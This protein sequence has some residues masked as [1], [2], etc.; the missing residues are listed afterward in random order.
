[1]TPPEPNVPGSGDAARA[2]HTRSKW[3]FEIG[4]DG[5]EQILMGIPPDLH[6]ALGAQDPANEPKLFKRYRDAPEVPTG[7]RPIEAVATAIAALVADGQNPGGDVTPDLPTLGRLLQ[8]SNGIL[9]TSTTP[10]GKEIA[11]RAAGQTGARFHLELYLVTGDLPGLPAGVYHYD[12]QT[13]ALRS[14][15]RGDYRRFVAQA[16]GEEPAIAAAPAILI[17]TSQIWRNAWRYL[18][19]SYRHVPWDMGTMLTNTLAMAASAEIPAEVVFGYADGAIEQLLGIDGKDELVAGLIALGRTSTPA[20]DSPAMEPMPFEVEPLSDQPAIMFPVIE[21]AYA[22]TSFPSGPA[23]NAWRAAIGSAPVMPPT[24]PPDTP[25]IPLR[26]TS[27]SERT[28]EDVIERR[29]SNR[30]YATEIPVSFEDFSTVLA[31][32]AAVPRLDVPFPPSDVYL[33]VNNVA[34]LEPG[35]YYYDRRANA[36]HLLKKGDFREAAKHLTVGQ[37]Y[38]ADANVVAFGLADLDA[39]YTVYGDRGYRMALFDAALF[40]GRMQLAAHALGLGAVGSVSQDDEIAAF[41]GAHADG[42]DFLFVAVFGAKRK[43]AQAERAGS[44]RFLN[45]DRT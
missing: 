31:H 16:S 8:R 36:L 11:Y 2:Y 40:G 1:M 14:L 34:E 9:K 22:G 6:P 21:A 17:V 29:R 5:T 20:P 39:I 3:W 26:P 38:A 12:A 24:A 32:A 4:P 19:R 41:F 42:K 45:A 28:I 37:Q 27:S 13:N 33:I 15:R 23:A 7:S 10:W 30:H 25:P 35:A 18:E 43:A 44:T